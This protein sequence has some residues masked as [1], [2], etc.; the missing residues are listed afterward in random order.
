MSCWG[1][2]IDPVVVASSF[3]MSAFFFFEV[4]SGL[5][6][7]KLSANREAAFLPVKVCLPSFKRLALGEC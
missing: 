6:S 7:Q 3:L 2:E 5:S 1:M 4:S